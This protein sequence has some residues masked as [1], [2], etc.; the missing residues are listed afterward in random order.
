MKKY[1]STLI[2]LALVVAMGLG[3][4]AC[5][6]DTTT[7]EPPKQELKLSDNDTLVEGS[8]SE[9]LLEGDAY[10]TNSGTTTKTLRFKFND[11]GKDPGHTVNFCFG[12]FCYP[13]TGLDPL[14]LDPFTLGPGGKEKL[15]VQLLPGGTA[16]T[17]DMTFTVYDVNNVADSIVYKVKFQVYF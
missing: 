12:N 8:K 10:I 11:A 16:G 6:D 4:A 7:P 9:A 17:T 1:T 15:K 2:V 14:T 3:F 13:T 5:S